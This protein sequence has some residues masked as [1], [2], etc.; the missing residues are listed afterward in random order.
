MVAGPSS[1]FRL[2]GAKALIHNREDKE[3]VAG[4]IQEIEDSHEYY[5]K[6][7]VDMG[8]SQK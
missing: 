3:S 2:C 1:L 6:R 5:I 7:I 8:R 4:W